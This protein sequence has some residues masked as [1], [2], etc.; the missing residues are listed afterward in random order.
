MANL[1]HPDWSFIIFF[2]ILFWLI[3]S[4]Q[5]ILLY[6]G[7]MGKFSNQYLPQNVLPPLFKKP[8][9]YHYHCA[10]CCMAGHRYVSFLFFQLQRTFLYFKCFSRHADTCHLHHGLTYFI[11]VFDSLGT[12]F[13]YAVP[14]PLISL[15]LI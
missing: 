15:F 2:K 1:Y 7:Y 9:V 6:E 13:Q 14:F 10:N 8:S 12:S 4:L 11:L 3:W 5:R